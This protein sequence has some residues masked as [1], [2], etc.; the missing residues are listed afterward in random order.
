MAKDFEKSLSSRYLMG[1][2]LYV[3]RNGIG[4]HKRLK[5]PIQ[6]SANILTIDT[7]ENYTGVFILA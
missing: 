7:K 3:V 6:L 2:Q 1:G 4:Q 5:Y